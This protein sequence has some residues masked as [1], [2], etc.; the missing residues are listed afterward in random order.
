MLLPRR[1]TRL[2]VARRQLRIV[3]PARVR[4]VE[5]PNASSCTG[6]G[7]GTIR[8]PR[9]ARVTAVLCA[10]VKSHDLKLVALPRLGERLHRLHEDVLRDVRS[11][12]RVAQDAPGEVVDAA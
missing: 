8:L 1:A 3:E 10:I 12:V 7:S 9:S 4:H 2:V 11:L 5:V 6:V